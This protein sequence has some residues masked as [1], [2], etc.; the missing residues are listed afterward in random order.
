MSTID[1][2]DEHSG[3]QCIFC[4]SFLVEREDDLVEG[5]KIIREVRCEKCKMTWKEVYILYAIEDVR[6]PGDS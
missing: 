5:S 4:D 2:Y 6:R 1:D 3:C